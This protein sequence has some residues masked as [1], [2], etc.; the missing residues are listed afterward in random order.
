MTATASSSATE[1]ENVYGLS[2]L[3]VPPYRAC[4]REDLPDFVFMSKAAKRRALLE[5]IE[6]VH[7]LGRP[8]LVGTV[9]VEESETLASDLAG[10]EIP[11]RVLNARNDSQEA[12]IVAEAGAVG[13][14]TISTNMAGRGTDIRLGGSD[15]TDRE[16]V[17]D[18]GGLYVIGTNRHESRRIDDQLRGRAGRQGDPGASRFF[19]CLEDALLERCGIRRLIPTRLLPPAGTDHALTH[20]AVQREIERSQRIIEGQHG[21]IR[22][23][24]L[25]YSQLIESQRENLQEI[26]QESLVDRADAAFVAISAPELWQRYTSICGEEVL[27]S[28][29]T[30]IKI[31]TIDSL[32][33]DH[34]DRVEALRDE[35]LLVQFDGRQPLVEYYRAAGSE[36]ERLEAR[37]ESS[38]IDTLRRIE[39]TPTGVDWEQEGLLGP[40]STWTYL[41][42]DS[43]YGDTTFLT[44]ATRPGLGMWAVLACWWLLLPW[45][46]AIHWKRWRQ[47]KNRN[48]GPSAEAESSLG[49][50][51]PKARPNA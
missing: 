21:D 41:V 48:P 8:I 9:S 19:I 16:R 2:V 44:L 20:P 5:E 3:Q 13:A 38:V 4:V 17:V 45:A 31:L 11:C 35:V 36:Y 24:L 46:A 18:L 10:H 29:V 7:R 15:E 33:A 51:D 43:A 1:L 40:S 14:V 39:V 49:P 12:E 34:L 27:R 25:R 37:I 26:R 22:S 42:N 32:W 47:R 30:R 23:R 50:D 28:I 6:A